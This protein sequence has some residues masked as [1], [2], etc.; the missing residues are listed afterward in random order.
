MV[1]IIGLVAE[2]MSGGHFLQLCNKLGNAA[3]YRS[4]NAQKEVGEYTIVTIIGL[5]AKW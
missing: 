2:E 3:V 1:S 4:R 5:V